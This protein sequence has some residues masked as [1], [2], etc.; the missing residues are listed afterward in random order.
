MNL[1]E[2]ALELAVPAEHWEVELR[3]GNQINVLCHGYSVEDNQVVFSLL[4]KGSPNFEVNTLTIPIS[5]M[6]IGFS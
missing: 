2:E 6:P 4:F 5:L 1:L 3:D